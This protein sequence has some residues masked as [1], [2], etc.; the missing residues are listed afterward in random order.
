MTVHV[1]ELTSEV[2]AAEEPRTPSPAEVS[3]WEERLRIQATLDRLARD[4]ARTATEGC[5]E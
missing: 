3:V 4:R 2:V 1:G 5:D